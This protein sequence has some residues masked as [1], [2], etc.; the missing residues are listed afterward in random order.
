MFNQNCSKIKDYYQFIKYVVAVFRF[1]AFS[2]IAKIAPHRFPRLL[3][4]FL[5]SAWN[6]LVTF[7]VVPPPNAPSSLTA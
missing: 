3:P 7:L 5:A 2:W 4:L 1:L 6:D